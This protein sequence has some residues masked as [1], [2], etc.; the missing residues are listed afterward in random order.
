MCAGSQVCRVLILMSFSDPF[1][2]ASGGLLSAPPLISSSSNL[3]FE[4]Q[5]RS[6]RLDSVLYKQETGDR[7]SS[8]PRRPTGSCC[9][10]DKELEMFGAE[11]GLIQG[12]ARMGGLLSKMSNSLI[13]FWEFLQVKFK[14]WAAGWVTLF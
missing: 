7:K 9:F 6:W 5:Q 2:L 4:I 10:K 11:E 13:V 3:P 12:Q 1:N 14:V 8:V